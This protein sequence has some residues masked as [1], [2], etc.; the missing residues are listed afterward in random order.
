MDRIE[1]IAQL[2]DLKEH[3][4]KT[5]LGLTALMELLIEKGV[6][7]RDQLALMAEKMEQE[8]YFDPIVDRS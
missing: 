4:Y 6:I 3:L 7:S 5:T 2:A 1:L 8:L